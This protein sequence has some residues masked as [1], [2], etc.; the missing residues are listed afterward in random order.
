[1]CVIG[2]MYQFYYGL[3]VVNRLLRKVGRA[4][5]VCLSCAI[6]SRLF[7]MR[8]GSVGGDLGCCS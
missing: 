3:L 4:P 1:M 2:K 6:F 8:G 7:Y 5:M